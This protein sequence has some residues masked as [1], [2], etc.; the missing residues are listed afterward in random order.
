MKM[1]KKL[2]VAC[3]VLFTAFCVQAATRYTETVNGITWTYTVYNGK[4]DV[5][6][7]SSSPMRTFVNMQN[8]FG[9]FRSNP[10]C[11]M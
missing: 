1:I 11:L 5:D 6:D 2:M 9:D 4:A 8:R 3:A 7:V 10:G